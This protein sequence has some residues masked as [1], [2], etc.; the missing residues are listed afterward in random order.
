MGFQN[1]ISRVGQFEKDEAGKYTNAATSL[2][3]TATMGG[4]AQNSYLK[5]TNTAPIT[6]NTKP[7]FDP[8]KAASDAS[9]ATGSE[10]VSSTP[11]ATM[12]SDFDTKFGNFNTTFSSLKANGKLE[13][14]QQLLQ[15]IQTFGGTLTGDGNETYL[16]QLADLEKQ[17]K[18]EI[19][20][21]STSKGGSV[22][23]GDATS[24]GGHVSYEQYLR[25]YGGDSM[26]NYL[27]SV[28]Y[29]NDDYYRSL[30]TYGMN[31]EALAG[32]GLTGAG[33]SSYGNDAAWAARQGA[34]ANAGAVK[35]AADTESA[36]NYFNYV[37]NFKA[38]QAAEVKE[39]NSKRYGVIDE[40]LK[41][42]ETNEETIKMQLGM[43]G[44]FTSE[45]IENYGKQIASGATSIISEANYGAAEELFTSSVG[46]LGINAAK[47]A[48]EQKFGV[49]VA[50]TVVENQTAVIKTAIADSVNQYDPAN[51]DQDAIAELTAYQKQGYLTPEEA[52]GHIATIQGKNAKY[53]GTLFEQA[54]DQ[55][56]A[57]K[58]LA[59]LGIEVAEGADAESI[60]KNAI[61]SMTEVVFDAYNAGQLSSSQAGD[62]LMADFGEE[63]DAILSNEE[64]FGDAI[65]RNVCDELMEAQSWCER[66]GRE[67][68]W[69]D[70]QKK[71]LENGIEITP[72]RE[73]HNREHGHN[74]PE[75]YVVKFGNRSQF[76]SKEMLVRAESIVNDVP[77]KTFMESLERLEKFRIYDYRGET[78]E[79]WDVSQVYALWEVIKTWEIEKSGQQIGN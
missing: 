29:A 24:E 60:M 41:S 77:A 9:V 7:T 70:F 50:N 53:Y 8:A 46:S 62:I 52:E 13:D 6:T 45:E 19:E 36:K 63:I 12:T 5:P 74:Y 73:E 68:L 51:T 54:R 38:A 76:I 66:L 34:I 67:D 20:K 49:D 40:L 14:Y 58:V 1:R 28:K 71:L 21:L 16:A 44:L 32:G 39:K 42:G 11:S 30:M 35:Q 33:V 78:N 72:L 2:S 57:D 27:A 31:A 61:D 18:A 26:K 47:Q 55:Y 3:P 43:S 79:V 69:G 37:Q 22:V 17:V 56:D 64:R 15:D 4:M 23:V 65:I 25:N 48:V 75:G 59:A 10:T